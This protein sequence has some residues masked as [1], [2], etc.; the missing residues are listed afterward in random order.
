MAVGSAPVVETDFTDDGAFVKL[1]NRV[2]ARED[3]EDGSGSMVWLM[4][5]LVQSCSLVTSGK[6]VRTMPS[7]SLR[8]AGT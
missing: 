8:P 6:I 2:L 7:T 3:G 4:T 1:L 5:M